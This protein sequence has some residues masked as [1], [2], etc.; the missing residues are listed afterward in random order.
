MS[1]VEHQSERAAAA[2]QKDGGVA[3]SREGQGAHQYVVKSLSRGLALLRL[4]DLERPRWT[5]GDLVCTSGLHKATCYR[6]LRTLEQEGFVSTDLATGQYCLGPAL[7]RLAILA[8]SRDE[9]L[10]T[11]G[12]HLLRLVEI[13]GETVDLTVWNDAGPLLVAQ[14][15]SRRRLFQPVSTVGT[16]FTEAPA[17]HVKLWLAFGT[18][19][20]ARRLSALLAATGAVANAPDALPEGAVETVRRDGVALDAS[21]AR[22][23]FSAAAPVFEA[24]GSMVAGLAVVAAFERAGQAERDLYTAAVR[25]VALALSREFGYLPE[26]GPATS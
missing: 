11:A 12:P 25:Q 17:S 26:S 13:T 16:V 7:A 23:V 14:E 19:S 2:A 18:E 4:F 21:R 20:Q 15:L 9:L 6:L 24:T 1:E 22:G 10:R 8:Q 5:L 3:A